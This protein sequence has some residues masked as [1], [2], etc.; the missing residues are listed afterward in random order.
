M[1]SRC[2]CGIILTMLF[3]ASVHLQSV[4]FSKCVYKPAK[5]K[6]S[7]AS[8]LGEMYPVRLCPHILPGASWHDRSRFLAGPIDTVFGSVRHFFLPSSHCSFLPSTAYPLR[9]KPFLRFI[10]PNKNHP[11]DEVIILIHLED[12]LEKRRYWRRKIN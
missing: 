9:V 7:F 8:I 11:H 6:V 5:L 10:L 3:R 12:E 2:V 1:T 4:Y